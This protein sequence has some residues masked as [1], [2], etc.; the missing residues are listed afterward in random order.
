MNSTALNLTPLELAARAGRLRNARLD[1]PDCIDSRVTG[2]GGFCARHDIP[3]RCCACGKA[4]PAYPDLHRYDDGV[5]GLLCETCLD[6]EELAE[7]RAE[8]A[9][10]AEM[11]GPALPMDEEETAWVQ[12]K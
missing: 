10:A 4:S 2:E 8:S 7:L 5:S 6:P 9:H 11:R 1:C 3:K 12:G